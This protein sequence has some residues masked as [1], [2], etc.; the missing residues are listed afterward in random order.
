[1]INSIGVTNFNNI[2]NAGPVT[3]KTVTEPSFNTKNTSAINFHYSDRNINLKAPVS[4]GAYNLIRTNLNSTEQEMYKN[5]LSNLPSAQRPQLETLLRK[6]ILLDSKSNDNSTVLENLNKIIEE[7]RAIG[8]DKRVVLS[9]L[10][11]TIS[12]PFVITQKFGNIPDKELQNILNNPGKY[13]PKEGSAIQKY[14]ESIRNVHSAACVAASIEFDLASK[15]PAEFARIA[16]GL[17]SEKISATKRLKMSDISP[18]WTEATWFLKEFNSDYKRIGWDEVEINMQPD[19]NAIVRARIQMT[20]KD[21]NERSLIDV[22]MQSTF[23]QIGSQQTYN[24]LTDT[25]TGKFNTDNTGLTDI[26]KSFAETVATG[27]NKCSVTYQQLDENGFITGYECGLE[28]MKKHIIDS[29]NQ[30]ENVIVGYTQQDDTGK[31]ING[32]EITIV[33]LE[34]DKNGKEVFVCNDTDDESDLPVRYYVDDL[35]PSIHHAGLSKYVID[36]NADFEQP[37]YEAIDYYKSLLDKKEN[38]IA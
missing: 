4:F 17:T 25:R 8:L 32:H 27:K 1:M 7:K 30:G 20:D 38:N 3:K 23:M 24:S 6:G 16:N 37:K 14:D 5:V 29:L 31:V 26:E 36:N 15:Q 19:R 2:Y 21:P 9:E 22:L 11:N 35:I 33:K 12:N 10:V 13:V 18:R 34:K 28:N